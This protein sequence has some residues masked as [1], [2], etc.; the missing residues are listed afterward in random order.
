MYYKLV[1]RKVVQTDLMD[2]ENLFGSVVERRIAWDNILSQ[3]NEGIV[4]CSISTVFLCID[5]NF[6]HGGAP[7]VFETAVFGRGGKSGEW[8]VV[9]RYSDWKSAHIGHIYQVE[10]EICNILHIPH[11]HGKINDLIP[12]KLKGAFDRFVI[13]YGKGFPLASFGLLGTYFYCRKLKNE[14]GD[15]TVRWMDITDPKSDVESIVD[16]FKPHWEAT[17]EKARAKKAE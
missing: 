13:D 5:H 12:V 14:N 1:D 3:N 8:D 4:S 6:Q 17:N 2:I 10:L 11:I 9:N 7:V 16:E 15:Y